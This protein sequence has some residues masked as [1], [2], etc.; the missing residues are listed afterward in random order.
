MDLTLDINQQIIAIFIVGYI[1]FI[2]VAI[3][4]F[5]G[6]LYK[7]KK[8]NAR[9]KLDILSKTELEECTNIELLRIKKL[10][11]RSYFFISLLGIV[12]LIICLSI[13]LYVISSLIL[14]VLFTF[15][16]AVNYWLKGSNVSSFIKTIPGQSDYHA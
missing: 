7:L 10:K 4:K 8:I 13:P 14:Y 9:F 5:H 2:S 6:S 15:M 1:V 11:K 3:S 16:L 12:H